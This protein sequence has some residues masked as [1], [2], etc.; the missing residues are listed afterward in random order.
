MNDKMASKLNSMETVAT[1]PPVVERISYLSRFELD[2]LRGIDPHAQGGKGTRDKLLDAAI[3]LFASRGYNACSMRE[4]AK[5]V[6]IGAPAIYNY[7]ASK[8]EILMAS[9][10]FVLSTF[11]GAVLKNPIPRHPEA[12]LFGILRR[13]V[14]FG[15]MNRTFARAADALLNKEL[16]QR[17]LPDS[18][19][20]RYTAAMDEYRKILEEL[21]R[22]VIGE[23]AVIDFA[24]QAF[25]VHEI[26]DRAGEWYEPA[27]PL[28]PADVADQCC[29]AVARMLGLP[30]KY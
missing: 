21:I 5:A 17:E 4:I 10:D 8:T 6:N 26:V 29:E 23:E 15:I 24:L 25:L 14:L 16:M 13:H 22:A 11:Y 19:R 9:L 2:G 18:H 27:S 7:F 12:A 3:D 20:Y 28:N 30:S 1:L